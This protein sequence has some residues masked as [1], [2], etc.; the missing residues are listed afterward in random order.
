MA[1]LHRFFNEPVSGEEWRAVR[2]SQRELVK[3]AY[4]RRTGR[5]YDRT[6]ARLKKVDYLLGRSVFKC[7]VPKQNDASGSTWLL[8]T[9]S[10]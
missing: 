6:S 10:A 2:G 5:M 9:T 7:L 8:Q 1:Q 3:A 4:E